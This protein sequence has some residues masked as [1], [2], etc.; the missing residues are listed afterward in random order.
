MT[1]CTPFLLGKWEVFYPLL[2]KTYL[3]K[4]ILQTDECVFRENTIHSLGELSGAWGS[5]LGRYEEEV[6]MA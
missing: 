6:T 1:L 5:I 3:L 4:C 2:F